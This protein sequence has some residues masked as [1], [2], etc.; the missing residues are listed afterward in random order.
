ML[1][2]IWNIF[3]HDAYQ[4]L[5]LHHNVH[6]VFLRLPSLGLYIF[7]FCILYE[8]DFFFR[9]IT[10]FHGKKKQ[11]R[12]NPDKFSR[13]AKNHERKNSKQKTIEN[14]WNY[15]NEW[16]TYCNKFSS[17]FWRK[18]GIEA[19]QIS[20]LTQKYWMNWISTKVLQQLQM[21]IFPCYLFPK[22]DVCVP[23]GNRRVKPSAL[24]YRT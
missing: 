19:R 18:N 15:Q 7:S 8:Q 10:L 3:F 21:E 12:Q 11:G 24:K 1:V 20:N 17:C 14:E 6:G 9:K 2:C 4:T 23:I 16:Q 22:K 13:N 5:S